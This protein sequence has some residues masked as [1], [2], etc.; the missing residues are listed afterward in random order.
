MAAAAVALVDSIAN[1]AEEKER[2]EDYGGEH[3]GR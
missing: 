2:H 3:E 1:E